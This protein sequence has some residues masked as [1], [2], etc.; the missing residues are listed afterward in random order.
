MFTLSKS[1]A[2]MRLEAVGLIKSSKPDDDD[3]ARIEAM[4][5]ILGGL[6][7]DDALKFFAPPKHEKAWNETDHPRGKNGKFMKRGGSEAV[8]TAHAKVKEILKG[9]KTAETHKQLIDHLSILTT[10]QLHQLKQK[11]QLSASGENKQAL[12]DKI[13]ERLGK[14]RVGDD[15]P[16]PT[17]KVPTYA[18]WGK[19]ERESRKKPAEV[20]KP[21]NEK[22]KEESPVS[23][24][25][26]A[27]PP[28]PPKPP[29]DSPSP[30]GDIPQAA[31]DA[32]KNA[33]P[34]TQEAM[35]VLNQ[36]GRKKIKRMA[37][38]SGVSFDDIMTAVEA[39][40]GKKVE[41]PD[42]RAE[43]IKREGASRQSS[44]TNTAYEDVFRKRREQEAEQIR[45]RDERMKQDSIDREADR[46]RFNK[47]SPTDQAK[48]IVADPRKRGFD[49][50]FMPKGQLPEGGQIHKLS[51]E[52]KSS[53]YFT[54]R[55][56]GEVIKVNGQLR[57]ITSVGKPYHTSHEDAGVLGRYQYVITR[58]ATPKEQEIYQ[59]KDKL[60]DIDRSFRT[61]TDY[62]ISEDRRAE[63]RK[64]Q[65][66]L[67]ARLNKL[68]PPKPKPQ[69]ETPAAIAPPQVQTVTPR[70]S[71]PPPPRP[72][73]AFHI[74]T[75][76]TF[77]HKDDIKR[78]GGRWD[79]DRK[80]WTI[81]ASAADRLPRGLSSRPKSFRLSKSFAQFRI[82]QHL[83][84]VT[85]AF[86]GIITDKNGRK[87]RYAN[88]KRVPMNA[89]TP[90]TAKQSAPK[91]PKPPTPKQQAAAAKKEIGG[92]S[93]QATAA[94]KAHAA[95]QKKHDSQAK[96]HAA[97]H[98]KH[99]ASKVKLAAA[100]EAHGKARTEKQKAAASKR[101]QT[102]TNAHAKTKL[103]KDSAARLL[104]AHKAAMAM[105]QHHAE[106]A[107]KAHAD[108]LAKHGEGQPVKNNV[109][110]GYK[111]YSDLRDNKDVTVE[112]IRAKISEISKLSKDDVKQIA[113]KA[114][115]KFT[116]QS[117]TEMLS[118]LQNSLE[119]IS[120]SQV[121]GKIIDEQ[122][123]SPKVDED[124]VEA[125]KPKKLEVSDVHSAIRAMDYRNDGLSRL[126]GVRQYLQSQ[127][128]DLTPAKFK[129]LLFKMQDDGD[130]ELFAQNE[131]RMLTDS[132]KKWAPSKPDGR[133]GTVWYALASAVS[134]DEKARREAARK[135]MWEKLKNQQEEY[136]RNKKR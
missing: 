33:P 105:A 128:H 125:A 24:S 130:I 102:A 43:R 40:T 133:G 35:L 9:G 91:Q 68:S 61:D 21:E 97:A 85:K 83:G 53:G 121:R 50:D 119:G 7:G 51:R 30:S 58:P 110:S 41:T 95:A 37:D 73:A 81:P 25:L 15:T 136:D 4:A 127:G 103:E 132:E 6:F 31:I 78:I 115:Y 84:I 22:P 8:D 18:E 131:V 27:D 76:N 104:K 19:Q 62:L 118:K 14:G 46:E 107:A 82:A 56:K 93:K 116:I 135:E 20:A 86:T 2:K 111:I 94:Q 29:Q 89:A 113:A 65:A 49:P 23:S 106:T 54:E 71:Q 120:T 10:K 92:A 39:V 123:Q 63:M 96:K 87:I 3:P 13:A 44:A 108:A 129:N 134:P 99:E 74:V 100:Q 1:F 66:E 12:R 34:G 101:L 75:G 55:E 88:G 70:P 28:K 114:G 117:K 42:Q 77:P 17:E 16:E 69:P 90:T 36:D 122:R 11:F 26:P 47:L 52:Q 79:A 109:D 98:G 64:E 124:P 38:Q 60:D 57:T 67:T 112:E 80:Q 72:P 48:E 32:V 5:D 45:Q 126:D 59:I